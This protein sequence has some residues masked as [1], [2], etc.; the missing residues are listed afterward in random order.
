MHAGMLPGET[1]PVTPFPAYVGPGPSS[2][3]RSA[4][5]PAFLVSDNGTLS[6]TKRSRWHRDPSA[7]QRPCRVSQH[8]LT[9]DDIHS[10]V[11]QTRGLVYELRGRSGQVRANPLGDWNGLDVYAYAVSRG[12]ELLPL[13]RCLGLMHAAEPWTLRK[14]WWLPGAG[15]ARG[16]V[17]W[18]ERYYPSLF[19]RLVSWLPGATLFR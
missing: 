13:Y 6:V 7:L 12:I 14:S 11:R 1:D 16:Q 10:R 18:L 15:A 9:G 4:R 19:R 2:P 17:V 3:Q 5:N 8:A